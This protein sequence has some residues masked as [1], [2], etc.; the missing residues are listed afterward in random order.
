VSP[1]EKQARAQSDE[2]CELVARELRVVLHEIRQP[3]AAIFALT[4]VARNRRDL[5]ADVR[6]L[7]STI[8]AEAQEVSA[9][10]SSAAEAHGRR[11]LRHIGP[12][13]VDDVLDS[14]LD[15]F[16]RTWT[17]NLRRRGAAGG[18]LEVAGGRLAVRRCLVN[19]LDNAVRASGPD[20]TVTVAVQRTRDR[21]RILVEDD[22][23]GFGKGPAGDGLGLSVT[24][25][26]LGQ[27]GGELSTRLPSRMGGACV[28]LLFPAQAHESNYGLDPVQAF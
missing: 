6:D 25:Q 4:E 14:V 22:G 21:V 2:L 27:M 11:P 3:L 12:V 5:P 9:A 19:V 16:R 1:A 7:L 17:G 28:G 15:S 18:R 10:A 23:P 20:G 13:D 8:I 26:L 24:R